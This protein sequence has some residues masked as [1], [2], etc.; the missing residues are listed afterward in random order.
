MSVASDR[1]ALLAEKY[2]T[3]AD[4]AVAVAPGTVGNTVLPAAV[5]VEKNPA[6]AVANVIVTSS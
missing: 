5:F 1:A 2:A 3:H 4:P 6:G